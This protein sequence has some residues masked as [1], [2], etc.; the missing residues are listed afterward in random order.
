PRGVHALVPG[1]RLPARHPDLGTTP[2]RR[3]GQPRLRPPLGDLPRHRDLPDRPLHQL[4]RRRTTR[5]VGSE[6]GS[7]AMTDADLC[8][9]PATELVALFRRRKVSPL[10][11]TRAVLERIEKVNPPLNA[12]CTVA[13]EQALA[14]AR[15]AT[16]ALKRRAKLGPLHG[17]P[18]SI[19]D[20]TLTQGIRTTEGSKIF[21]HR[22]SGHDAL[23]VERLQAAGSRAAA[24]R[25]GSCPCGRP[26]SRGIRGASR[27][28][29]PGPSPIPP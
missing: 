7:G 23:V 22:I 2:V 24:P 3:Q 6:E 11:L 28:R 25:P 18:V 17:I 5:R 10:E 9:T 26:R 1:P 8:F 15:R 19:K 21:E 4:H 12:Y 14:A 16:A 13:A 29:W 20:L 27:G